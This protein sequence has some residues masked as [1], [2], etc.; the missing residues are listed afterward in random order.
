M[1]Q[2]YSPSRRIALSDEDILALVLE[3]KTH[4]QHLAW[5]DVYKLMNQAWYG[6]THIKRDKVFVIAGITQEYKSLK[7]CYLPLIQDIGNKK[8]YIRLSISFIQFLHETQR[9]T[10]RKRIPK[11]EAQ[12]IA[13]F[14][15]IVLASCLPKNPN[16]LRWI[17]DFKRVL[18]LLESNNIVHTFQPDPWHEVVMKSGSMPSHSTKYKDKYDPHYR[19]VHYKTLYTYLH[20]N[21]L[22]EV[23]F[24]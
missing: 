5:E 4:H 19:V 13:D 12:L 6:P 2:L 20:H 8:G 11:T 3:E 22:L 1:A 21:H 14:A 18:N 9:Q 10:N 23:H 7:R 24:E 17:S 15:D 16:H